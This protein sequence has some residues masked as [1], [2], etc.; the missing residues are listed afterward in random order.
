MMRPSSETTSH[1]AFNRGFLGL[2]PR[3]GHQATP[4]VSTIYHRKEGRFYLGSGEPQLVV[5]IN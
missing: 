2:S 5:N 1:T 3:L 4:G